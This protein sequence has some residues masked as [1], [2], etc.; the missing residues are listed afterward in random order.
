LPSDETFGLI[1]GSD[2]CYED[3]LPRA[4]AATVARRLKPNGVCWL[5]LPVRA[6]PNETGAAVIARLVNEFE[7]AGMRVALEKAP[8]LADEEYEGGT[9]VRHDGGMVSVFVTKRD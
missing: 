2:V 4:L 3:P 7:R 1:V 5:V 6:W 9:F 8:D